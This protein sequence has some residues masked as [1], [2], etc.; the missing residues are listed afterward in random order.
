MTN[1]IEDNAYEALNKRYSGGND[2]AFGTSF[3]D[4][5]AGV[6][7]RVPDGVD[8]ADLA[9]Y[10]L[11]LGDDALV[12]A[13]RLLEWVTHGPE[14]EQELALANLSLDLQGQ[15]RLL[16]ARAAAA[17][18]ACVPTLPPGSPVPAEDAL[19][20]FRDEPRFKSIRLVE[21]N[22]GD[23]AETVVR[24]LIFSTFRL[25][26]FSGLTASC[27]PVL[28][29]IARKSVKEMAYHRDWAARW[30]RVFGLG[31]DE[32]RRRVNAALVRL[33][34]F[35][36]EM[37]SVT[38]VEQRLLAAHISVAPDSLRTEFDRVLDEVFDAAELT[39]PEISASGGMNGHAG[40]EGPHSEDLG[41]MLAV[42]QSTARA[43]PMG[44]W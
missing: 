6:D 15:A 12:A 19:A 20:F 3:S 27:D 39:R 33:W 17:D 37:F 4:P 44:K 28:A 25:A 13:Q 11:M 43:C 9:A 22:N 23:F 29:A 21:L 40:R 41:P 16:L 31:T 10:C 34:P 1:K 36:D 35:V 8:H 7:T 5:L 14:L 32:S 2:W 30:M 26:Q 42:M 18:P 38:A 24:T